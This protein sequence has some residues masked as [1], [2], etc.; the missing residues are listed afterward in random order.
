MAGLNVCHAL[1]REQGEENMQHFFVTTD[2]VE[3]PYIYIEGSDVNHMKN[4]LRMKTGERLSVSDGDNHKYLCRIEGY[5]EGRAALEIL[6]EETADTELASKIYL[7]QGLPKGD[8]MEL[9]IQKAVELGVYRVVPVAMKRCVVRLD[10]GK[11]EKKAARWNEIAKGAAKQSGR[12]RIPE[13]SRVLELK[14][15]LAL[16]EELD[17]LLIPYELAEGMEHTRQVIGAI[18]PGQSVG[19]FI[20]PEGGF[21]KEEVAA[22]TLAGAKEITLGRRILRTETAGLA[23]LSVL[24]YHLEDTL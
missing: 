7:F 19:I 24:M 1:D 3:K 21:E 20:G 2:R 9:I 17:I 15:A 16:A 4:V 12:G 13:V 11:A 8:K 14:E 6:E 22:A 18:K 5:G 10:A 23:V